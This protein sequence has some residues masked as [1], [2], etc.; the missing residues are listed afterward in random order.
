MNT[1]KGNCLLVVIGVLFFMLSFSG[2]AIAQEPPVADAGAD[3]TILL[4]TTT[5]LE[6]SATDPNGDPIV[7]WLWTV[8]MAPA[9]SNPII[10]WPDQPDPVFLADVA[11]YYVLALIAF[12]GY[13]WSEPDFVTINVRALLPP[14]SMVDVD[15]TSG[16]VPL[17][18]QFDG[19]A[20]FVDPFA[21]S[22]IYRWDF[23]DGEI[24]TEVSPTHIYTLPGTY[25]AALRVVDD[26]GQ[27]DVDSIDIT[28]TAPNNPPVASPTATPNNGVAP[29]VVQ[30]NANASDPDG[31]DLTYLWD[32]G[33]PDSDDNSST[34]ENPQHVYEAQGTYVAWL[35]VS[36][37]TDEVT[38]SVPVVVT[39]DQLLSTRR[40]TVVKWSLNNRS[41]KGMISYWADLNLPELGPDDVVAFR[42]DGKQVFAKPYGDFEPGLKPNVLLIVKRRLQV[43]LNLETN[44]IYIWARKV[45][46]RKFDNSDG[47]D[48]ELLWGD[49]IAVDQFM[50]DQVTDWLWNYQRDE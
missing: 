9:D 37:G 38:A 40:A 36:D 27:S 4:D 42:F 45:N 7:K 11:G 47:V 46:L 22:L 20:S 49:K 39:A 14:E 10:E 26:L 28:V 29:L 1:R 31:D 12:D 18:V 50:M 15:T 5:L 6:G 8:D 34:L 17:T 48:V 44:R 30:F 3:Q 13:A 35:T 23:G 21:G 33:D 24:S 2:F 16:P 19:S 41:Q 32:F 43:R 25:N